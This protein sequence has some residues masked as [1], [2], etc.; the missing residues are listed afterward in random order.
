MGP[1][2]DSQ[3][4]HSPAMPSGSPPARPMRVGMCLPLRQSG[5][6]MESAGMMQCWDRRQAPAERERPGYGPGCTWPDFDGG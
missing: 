1:D 3:R 5:S 6:Q 4:S 2:G